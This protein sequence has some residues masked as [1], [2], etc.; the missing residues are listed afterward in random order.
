MG[1]T[2]LK[3]PEI[4]PGYARTL[5]I[6]G[7]HRESSYGGKIGA[8]MC[9][10]QEREE[11]VG[12]PSCVYVWQDHKSKLEIRYLTLPA[13][14]YS[15]TYQ[16]AHQCQNRFFAAIFGVQIPYVAGTDDG[17]RSEVHCNSSLGAPSHDP[18]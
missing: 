11:C 3:C 10:E 13:E 7:P 17:V 8:Q 15:S 12:R 5:P 9:R 14:H 2:T 18:A 6:Q 1:R 4:R 16:K